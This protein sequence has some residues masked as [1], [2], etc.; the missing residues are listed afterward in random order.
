MTTE[1][2]YNVIASLLLLFM[3]I[4]GLS[5]TFKDSI[6][7]DEVAHIP[8]GFSYLDKHDYRLNPEHPPLVKDLAALPLLFLNLTFPYTSENWDASSLDNQWSMGKDFLFSSGN[9]L[10]KILFWSR[11]P[12]LLIMI[13]LG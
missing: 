2:K 12:M 10:E 1:R 4:C 9:N 5:S 6:T 3:F 8:A 13:L 11:L 7:D